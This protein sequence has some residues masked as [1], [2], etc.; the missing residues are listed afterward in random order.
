MDELSIADLGKMLDKGEVNSRKLVETY[1]DRIDSIDRN[2]P[3][4]NSI[5]E[6]NPE[7]L[8]IA[9]TLDI[10]RTAIGT[11]SPLHGIPVILKDNIDTADQMSTTAGSLA[12]EGHIAKQD[13]FVASQ[14]RNAGAIILAKANLSEW[15]NFRSEHSTSGWSSRGGQTHNPYALDRNPCLRS[16][17]CLLAQT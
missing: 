16:C 11:R 1:L 12:L 14:L 3:G 5:I 4:L 7:A 6:L 17:G 10:E 13:S 2:S 9:D 8:S 15:A